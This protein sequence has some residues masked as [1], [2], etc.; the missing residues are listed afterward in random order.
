MEDPVSPT[1]D[2][3]LF[4]LKHRKSTSPDSILDAS[5]PYDKA[6]LTFQYFTNSVIDGLERNDP[7]VVSLIHDGYLTAAYSRVPN[8]NY[9]KSDYMRQW[10]KEA[11][12]K[13]PLR[14]KEHPFYFLAIIRAQNN[15]E[16]RSVKSRLLAAHTEFEEWISRVFDPENLV[17]DP[18]GLWF[19][20]NQNGIKDV[21]S[22]AVASEDPCFIC[23]EKFDEDSHVA[24]QALCGHIICG[25][26]FDKWLLECRGR[27]NCPMCRACVV[28]G[29]NDCKHHD[30]QQ[31]VAAPF[32]LPAI[33]NVAL[34]E[35]VSQSLHGL[36]PH[37]YFRL[38]EETRQDR[39]SA[40]WIAILIKHT[41]ENDPLF[42]RFVEDGRELM[43]SIVTTCG[44][45]RHYWAAE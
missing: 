9:Y 2:A 1:I 37:I 28:C 43:Q 27:Y 29:A 12:L 20:R 15:S 8:T 11:M 13:H 7:E 32:P 5:D 26:C 23:T 10:V 16:L 21:D 30:V 42:E 3:W 19:L 6:M 45:D 17:K 40:A 35:A 31:E 18:S 41:P 44:M 25:G 34:P 24:K 36:D 14:R 33:L 4:E 38:R 39:V 22:S